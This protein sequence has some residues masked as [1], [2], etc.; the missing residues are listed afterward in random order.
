[1][2]EAGAG[3]RKSNGRGAA[4]RIVRAS[5]VNVHRDTLENVAIVVECCQFQ[6][7]QFPI[8]PRARRRPKMNKRTRSRL[9]AFANS[10][11]VSRVS[12][13]QIHLLFIASV[14]S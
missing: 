5:R 9:T 7:C 11:A 2:E 1:M 8:T 13:E 4:K 6:C 10:N 3:A 14:S 12:G